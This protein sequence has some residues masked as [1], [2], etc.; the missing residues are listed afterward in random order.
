MQL[1]PSFG[2][3]PATRVCK[4]G[5]EAGACKPPGLR[6]RCGLIG[7]QIRRGKVIHPVLT[8]PCIAGKQQSGAE[9]VGKT[10][11]PIEAGHVLPLILASRLLIVGVGNLEP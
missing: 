3:V 4:I 2:C 11:V 9:K 10:E 8:D 6:E 7:E 1:H 5:A